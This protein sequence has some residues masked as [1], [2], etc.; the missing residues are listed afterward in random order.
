MFADSAKSKRII[1]SLCLHR[2]LPNSKSHQ[3]WPTYVDPTTSQ[4]FNR[5]VGANTY[6][7]YQPRNQFSYY[8]TPTTPPHSPLKV[9]QSQSAAGSHLQWEPHMP[10]DSQR[11][12]NPCPQRPHHRDTFRHPRPG[13]HTTYPKCPI[14]DRHTAPNPNPRSI[15]QFPTHTQI[16]QTI[17]PPA[18]QT[19]SPQ[20]SFQQ[21]L[22]DRAP[23][24]SFILGNIKFP[25][26]STNWSTVSTKA[27][28]PWPPTAQSEAQTAHSPG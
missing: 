4:L 23:S 11:H 12:R 28:L 6:I 22:Q 15:S 13:K 16:S 26:S 20:T 10:R 27:V 21:Y 8:P 5:L 9:S 7:I 17:S 3:L 25:S 18:T 19:V 2:W 24:E 14:P 1:P